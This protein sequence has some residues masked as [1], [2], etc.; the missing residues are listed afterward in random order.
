MLNRNLYFEILILAVCPI[1]YFDWYISIIAKKGFVIN[2]LA[3]DF[4]VAFMWLRFYFVVR[5]FFNYSIYTDAYSKKLCQSYGFTAGVRFTFKCQLIINPGWTILYLMVSSI[6]I[7]ANLLRIF[8][9][10]YFRLEVDAPD[11]FN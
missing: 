9:M 2:Y 5:T 8:E 7:L 3:S 1:P 10:P 4:I 6:G 11:L